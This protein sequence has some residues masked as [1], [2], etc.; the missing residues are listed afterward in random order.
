MHEGN[1][2]RQGAA[3]CRGYSRK[4]REETTGRREREETNKREEI[5]R[6]YRLKS[7]ERVKQ[8]GKKQQYT[9]LEG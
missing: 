9:L 4:Q 2:F 5:R 3:G 7:K 8:K 1:Q 6:F